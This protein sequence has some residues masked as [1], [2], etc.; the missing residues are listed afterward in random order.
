MPAAGAEAQAT[1][2]K[3]KKEKEKKKFRK[4][5]KKKKERAA[6]GANRAGHVEST[7]LLQPPSLPLPKVAAAPVRVPSVLPPAQGLRPSPLAS[8]KTSKRKR[9]NGNL[10]RGDALPNPSCASAGAQ[11]S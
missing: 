2:K 8:A 10:D 7:M 6:T 1:A 5:K 4:D 9:R 11:G 3:N